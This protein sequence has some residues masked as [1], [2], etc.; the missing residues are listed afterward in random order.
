MFVRPVSMPLAKP[1][2]I[3]LAA[4]PWVTFESIAMLGLTSFFVFDVVSTEPKIKRQF[5]LN[6]PLTNEP[7]TE[8]RHC[9]DTCL[10]IATECC[11]SCCCC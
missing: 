5:V 11:D 2:Q 9:F 1:K 10:A 4:Q 7:V 6:V 3:A 8:K